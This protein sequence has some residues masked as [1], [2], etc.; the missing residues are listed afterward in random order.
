MPN[1][2]VRS[3]IGTS[4]N[5]GASSPKVAVAQPSIIRVKLNDLKSATSSSDYSGGVNAFLS[6]LDLVFTVPRITQVVSERLGLHSPNFIS[7]SAEHP[8]IAAL[9]VGGSTL[10]ALG[11][12]GVYLDKL[13][14]EKD[15]NNGIGLYSINLCN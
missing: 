7:I 12:L 4:S 9:A 15:K 11:H 5:L 3:D 1:A 8:W 6:I 2:P 13:Q 14:D 10:L